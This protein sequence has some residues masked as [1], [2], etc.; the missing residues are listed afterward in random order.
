MTQLELDAEIMKFTPSRIPQTV[1]QTER[2]LRSLV[3]KEASLAPLGV[4]AAELNGNAEFFGWFMLMKSEFEFPEL[5]FMIV[6]KHW[7][8]GLATEVA[9]ALIDFGMNG[10]NLNGLTAATDLDNPASIRV[11]EKLG[12]RFLKNTSKHDKIRNQ[13][14]ELAVY[15]LRK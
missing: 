10:L 13:D 5:G 4:W 1:D 8:K 12:F 11:L 15:E 9:R 6:R 7:G 2:R 14:I 3:E